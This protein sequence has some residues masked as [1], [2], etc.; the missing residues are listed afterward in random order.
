MCE[1]KEND[2]VIQNNVD[3]INRMMLSDELDLSKM[4]QVPKTFYKGDL[5][6][7]RKSNTVE[8][9][10]IAFENRREAITDIGMRFF[11]TPFDHFPSTIISIC[12]ELGFPI[13]LFSRDQLAKMGRFARYDECAEF[14]SMM[15]TDL[16]SVFGV[17]HVWSSRLHPDEGSRDYKW[18]MK[19][20]E[21]RERNSLYFIDYCSIPQVVHTCSGKDC[22]CERE[23]L[24][25]RI[26]KTSLNVMPHLFYNR[27]KIPNLNHHIRFWCVV[28]EIFSKAEENKIPIIRRLFNERDSLIAN[29]V[30][31]KKS[32]RAEFESLIGDM[33]QLLNSL[34]CSD[35]SDMSIMIPIV[36]KNIR[37]IDIMDIKKLQMAIDDLIIK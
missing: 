16:Y 24:P 5:D 10:C 33:K 6:K 25:N 30:T 22:T 8:Q 29:V 19:F 7:F 36:E 4:F 17:S 35:M 12:E 9:L 32:N 34:S 31:G 11:S 23:E 13:K 14:K 2:A 26:F 37:L 18:L 15:I 27:I 1:D 21:S 20:I 3:E 28:E